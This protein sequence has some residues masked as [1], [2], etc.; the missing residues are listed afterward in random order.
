MFGLSTVSIGFHKIE[1]KAFSETYLYV[2]INFLQ[3]GIF[4]RLS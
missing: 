1:I 2:V 4:F 3:S